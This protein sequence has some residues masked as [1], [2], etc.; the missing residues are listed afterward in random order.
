MPD[1]WMGAPKKRE[2]SFFYAVLM[3]QA[4]EYCEA[5]VRDCRQQRLEA[6]EAKIQRPQN[7]V[8]AANWVAPLLEQPYLPGK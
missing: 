4:P 8:I 3:T 7:L 6:Q 1:D 2:R 5:L